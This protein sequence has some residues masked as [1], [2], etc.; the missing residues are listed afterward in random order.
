MNCQHQFN[1]IKETRRRPKGLILSPGAV[2]TDEYGA[3]IGCPI[4]G[5]IRTIW[6]NGDIEINKR[7]NVETKNKTSNTK[8]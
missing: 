6:E 7:G 4:C 1:H 8:N 2:W 3:M 5:E